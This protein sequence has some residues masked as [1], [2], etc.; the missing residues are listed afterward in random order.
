MTILQIHRLGDRRERLFPPM[1]QRMRDRVRER[2][3]VYPAYFI[4]SPWRKSCAEQDWD[5]IHNDSSS[6]FL[7]ARFAASQDSA[8][9]LH[10]TSL[11]IV[12][13]QGSTGSFMFAKRLDSL[14]GCCVGQQSSPVVR[15]GQQ[16]CFHGI[17]SGAALA[18][19]LLF[20]SRPSRGFRFPQHPGEYLWVL[21]GFGVA[22]RL[23]N[24]TLATIGFLGNTEGLEIAPQ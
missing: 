4:R 19:L 9:L 15:Q 21:L 5:S 13:G 22:I 11:E 17:G 12:V 14:F 3:P 18:G 8:Q 6:G 16:R 10:Q 1:P 20:A 7:R 2:N 23:L 24:M